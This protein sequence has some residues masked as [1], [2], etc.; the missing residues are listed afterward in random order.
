[1]IYDKNYFKNT[2]SG[3]QTDVFTATTDE[4]KRVYISDG[5][6][7]LTIENELALSTNLNKVE[8]YVNDEFKASI[9]IKKISSQCGVLLKWFN[10]QLSELEKW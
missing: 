1:M 3:L 5:S 6:T 4:V 7:N 9:Y 10:A 2:N 8:L